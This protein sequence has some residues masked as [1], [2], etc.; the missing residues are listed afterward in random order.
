MI[1]LVNKMIPKSDFSRGEFVTSSLNCNENKKILIKRHLW[2]K[3]VCL[4]IRDVA[5]DLEVRRERG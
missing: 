1:S 5:K 3:F 2:L 4:L